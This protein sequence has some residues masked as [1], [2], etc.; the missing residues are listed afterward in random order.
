MRRLLSILMTLFALSGVVVLGLGAAY[1]QR[2]PLVPALAAPGPTDVGAARA[3][4]RRVHS[5]IDNPAEVARSISVTPV[6]LNAALRLGA[7]VLPGFRAT[8]DLAGAELLTTVSIPVPWLSGPRWLNLKIGLRPF[9]GP[10]ALSSVQIGGRAVPPP[11]T[12][13]LTRI[14]LNLYFGEQMG[15]RLFAAM[16]GLAIE[17]N[18]LTL[19]I[20]PDAKGGMME[21]VIGALRDDSMPSAQQIDRYAGLIATAMKDGTLPRRGSLMPHLKFTLTAAYDSSTDA[22]AS[23]EFAA[24]ILGLNAVCGAPEF[25]AVVD[26]LAGDKDPTGHRARSDCSAI[27][28]AGR[29]D[30][31]LHFVTSA[32]I[33]AAGNRGLALSMGEFKELF[34]QRQGGSKFDFTDIAADNSG[35][36]LSDLFMAAPR[37]DWPGL[38]ARLTSEEAVLADFAGLPAPMGDAQFRER[39]GDV[40]SDSYRD[41]IAEIETRIDQTGL[42]ATP[43]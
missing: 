23:E 42:H 22:T 11:I 38:I 40:A 30:S 21:G 10:P 37:G 16:R 5:A 32:A 36:R 9:D 3:L 13:A 14:G 25:A 17:G 39:F 1:L 27:T 12:L 2:T 26:E 43:P 18:K 20:D 28:L 8:S 6:E 7:R 33:K 15:D 34:D 24:A 29:K 41:L 35:V 4:A 31:R 19:A